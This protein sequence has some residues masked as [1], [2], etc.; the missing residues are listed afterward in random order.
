MTRIPAVLPVPGLGSMS[1]LSALV[2]RAPP[3]AFDNEAMGIV[4]QVMWQ[5]HIRWYYVIDTVVFICY[6]AL[7]I[8][9]IEFSATKPAGADELSTADTY[10]AGTILVI[11][12]LFAVKEIVQSNLGR[13]PGYFQSFWN[14]VDLISI[15]LVYAYGISITVSEGH[16][17]GKVQLAVVTTLLL[18]TKLISYLRAFNQTGWLVTVLSRNFW[19]VRGFLLVLLSIL[20]GFSASFRVLFATTSRLV[21]W[22]SNQTLKSW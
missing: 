14:Q 10:I 19:D 1:F 3:T 7:W 21:P 12:S 11:N 16:N 17:N 13:R 2:A 8:L 18:T 4:L 15:L 6:Y 22:S 20:V 5:Y 9:L